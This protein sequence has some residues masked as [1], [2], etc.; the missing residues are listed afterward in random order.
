MDP[1]T[2]KEG[3]CYLCDPV[4]QIDSFNT[5]VL[6]TLKQKTEINVKLLW[7][8]FF[9]KKLSSF[10]THKF[11]LHFF[12]NDFYYCYQRYIFI[13]SYTFRWEV[14]TVLTVKQNC[15]CMFT[16]LLRS[17]VSLGLKSQF[18]KQFCKHNLVGNLIHMLVG[19]AWAFA[20]WKRGKVH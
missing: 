4:L 12:C 19:H 20:G 16:T 13:K 3:I 10:D 2:L 9:S 8:N 6:S 15:M 1:K 5:K 7:F 18:Y 14:N 17:T 11:I